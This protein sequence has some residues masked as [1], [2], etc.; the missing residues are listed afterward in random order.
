MLDLRR[1]DRSP[2]SE[3]YVRQTAGVT[4]AGRW[5]IVELVGIELEPGELDLDGVATFELDA[6]GH[7]WFSVWVVSASVDA[8]PTTDGFAFTYDGEWEFDH[9]SGRGVAT[10]APDGSI[11]VELHLHLGDDFSLRAI[12]LPG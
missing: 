1:S 8:Y 7:G 2:S 6:D 5:Q 4:I 3:I 9:I 11:E 10:K 12:P